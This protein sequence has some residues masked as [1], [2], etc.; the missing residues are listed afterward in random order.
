MLL[1]VICLIVWAKFTAFIA[2]AVFSTAIFLYF[3]KHIFWLEK[4]LIWLKT[5]ELESLPAGSGIWE[6]VFSGLYQFQ[7]RHQRSQAQL[8]ST[9]DRF[10]HAASA[11]PDGVVLLNAQHHIEWC[12]AP[13]E[14]LLGLSLVKDVG[15][16]I[17]YLIRHADFVDYLKD[18]DSNESIKMRSWI[19]AE[20]VLEIQLVSFGKNQKLL[21]ARDVSQVE[22]LEH[23]RRDF[24]ANVSH[25]L[26]TPLT[27]VGGFLETL[28]DMDD[29][30]PESLRGYFGMMQDQT[31]R[32]RS[33]IEDLLALSQLESSSLPQQDTD[34][35]VPALLNKVLSESISLSNG[36]HQI[37]FKQ[38]S[39]VHLTGSLQELHS[40]FG[41]LVGNAIRYT[42]AGGQIIMTWKM[43]G[44]D[45]VFVVQD[46]GIGIEQKHIDRLTER[47]YR[48]DR[49]RSRETGGTGLGL[50]IVKHILTRHLGWLEIESEFGKG[51]IFSAVFSSERLVNNEADKPTKL[52]AVF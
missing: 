51:S 38:E 17:V 23:M 50:S 52:V 4:L 29:A 2:M 40:A 13:A 9:L 34:V 11:L 8:S 43:R 35:D 31:A 21:I 33:L 45:A 7:R 22:K 14:K 15:Q 39:N 12:N 47:F 26:R 3:L 5:A 25:E 44:A 46:T 41:N 30:V 19:S 6:D 49:S 32:M 20:I 48:V 36:R 42:P 27:V 28:T 16:R 24:I 10:M 1:V 37:S 18:C